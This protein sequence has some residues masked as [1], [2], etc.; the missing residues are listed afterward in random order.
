MK[1]EQGRP[2]IVVREYVSYYQGLVD[3]IKLTPVISQGTKKRLHGNDAVKSHI[4][5]ART[6]ANI[7][8]SSLVCSHSSSVG[9]YDT[10]VTQGA[11]RFGQNPH[12]ARRRYYRNK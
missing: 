9:S 12:L 4:L 10:N 3:I 8:K 11:P 5:A 7:V 2:F 1:D 6:V